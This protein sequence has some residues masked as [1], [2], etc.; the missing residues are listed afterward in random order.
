MPRGPRPSSLPEMPRTQPPMR[1]NP[2][3]QPRPPRHGPQGRRRRRLAGFEREAPRHRF[4]TGRFTARNRTDRC[5]SVRSRIAWADMQPAVA[6]AAE[7]RLGRGRQQE[8]TPQRQSSRD[9]ALHGIPL[10]YGLPSPHPC[11]LPRLPLDIDHVPPVFATRAE[12]LPQLPALQ[13]TVQPADQLPPSILTCQTGTDGESQQIP[14]RSGVTIE[15]QSVVSGR[16][17]PGVVEPEP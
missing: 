5:G 13:N 3:P 6:C 1:R 10:S 8:H 16:S 14:D 2:P 15:A 17:E 11:H 12:L 4:L 7:T 9:K